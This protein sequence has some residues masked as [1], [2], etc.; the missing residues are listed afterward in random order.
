MRIRAL[1]GLVCAALLTSAAYA[2]DA[3]WGLIQSNDGTLYVVVSGMRHRVQPVVAPD[4]V[5]SALPEGAAWETGVMADAPT[6]SVQ[7]L[8]FTAAPLQAPTQAN[9]TIEV[10]GGG[11]G[12]SGQFHL[13]G[14]NYV[15]RWTA[16]PLSATGCSLSG[17]LQL[18]GQPQ[19][20]QNIANAV[21]RDA[22]RRS[23][24]TRAYALTPGDY[25]LNM[26]GACDWRVTVTP[27]VP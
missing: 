22:V 23:G 7:A 2:Q 11:T 26:S 3:Q 10:E 20:Q 19:F 13:S 24:D 9:G 21:I 15:I 4:D 17:V 16:T 27:Q 12:Q 1:G 25:F 6:V 5:I 14:G 18:R 8:T